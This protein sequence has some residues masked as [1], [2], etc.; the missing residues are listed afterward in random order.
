MKRFITLFFIISLAGLGFAQDRENYGGEP[1]VVSPPGAG[2]GWFG[3][4]RGSVLHDNGPLVNSPGTGVG[5]ADES[6]L[7]N[8]SLG[9]NTLGFGHQVLNNNRVADEFTITGADWLIDSITF[10]AYQTNS[11]TTSP[12]TSVNFQIWDGPPGAGG[13]NVVFGDTATNRLTSTA[14]SG[15]YRVSETTTG[16]AT[17]RPIMAN[18][19]DLVGLVLGAGT[20]WLDWQTDGSLASGPWA[21][22]ININ[23]VA[24]TGNGQQSLGGA[25][26]TPANDSGTGTPQQGFPFIIEGQIAC[27]ITS[28]QVRGLNQITITGNCPS[29]VD[30]YYT[31]GSG[32]FLAAAGIVINGSLTLNIPLEPDSI[33]FVGFPGDPNPIDGVTSGRTVP[34]LGQWGMIAFILLLVGTSVYFMRRKRHA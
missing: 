1:G 11:T 27:S 2:Q 18:Q 29:Q 8:T 25:A 33:Y 24:S 31:N 32:T 28:I 21:P 16:T 22:P 4:N 19:C 26:F 15:I 3:P 7:Q 9:M 30:L 10:F 14:W 17:N 13:S 23:G 20:Y 12:I 34:T 5:G 6:V